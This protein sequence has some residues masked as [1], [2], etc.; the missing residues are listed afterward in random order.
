[1]ANKP[2]DKFSGTSKEAF[3]PAAQPRQKRPRDAVL[4]IVLEEL[5]RRKGIDYTVK[6]TSG[7]AIL[8]S[9]SIYLAVYDVGD[10]A[11]GKV[12]TAFYR[13][14]INPDQ[15]AIRRCANEFANMAWL[16]AGRPRNQAARHSTP[17][18]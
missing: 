15:A 4:A 9:G 12:N 2:D 10:V 1:M 13:D 6:H 18:R 7:S 5:A 8:D 14:V 3:D 11:Y 16:E 17:K